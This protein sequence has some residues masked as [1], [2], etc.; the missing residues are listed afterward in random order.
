MAALVALA[1]YRPRRRGS[2]LARP[3]KRRSPP[4]H[5]TED[6]G[7]L[8]RIAARKC[9]QNVPRRAVAGGGGASRVL[10]APTMASTSASA[11]L[12]LRSL[13][14][15]VQTRIV[16]A[17]LDTLPVDR[18]VFASWWV[19]RLL[20][21]SP[22]SGLLCDSAY[23]PVCARAGLKT[24]V[25]GTWRATYHQLATEMRRLVGWNRKRRRAKYNVAALEQPRAFW[26]CWTSAMRNAASRNCTLF[27][28]IL[29]DRCKEGDARL[30]ATGDPDVDCQKYVYNDQ[31]ENDDE[32]DEDDESPPFKE[33]LAE[34]QSK[35]DNPLSDAIESCA[36]DAVRILLAAGANAAARHECGPS[37]VA[38]AAERGALKEMDLLLDAGAPLHDDE[39]PDHYIEDPLFAAATHGEEKTTRR[40]LERGADPLRLDRCGRTPLIRACEAVEHLPDPESDKLNV[41]RMLL[42]AGVDPE[43]RANNGRL[44]ID[45]AYASGFSSIVAALAFRGLDKSFVE[46]EALA[47]EL[48][49]A[50]V[51][52]M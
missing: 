38:F 36:T 4:L 16:A 26:G 52:G 32:N 23:E 49:A 25:C 14:L 48:S 6:V 10:G 7:A 20:V 17:V 5:F 15:D 34:L 19:V 1:P 33:R 50:A 18:A 9:M 46:E 41:V 3:S 43:V 12:C 42:E 28:R 35:F 2:S 47:D 11:A 40:L 13:P 45:V 22:V 29:L 37:L 21:E 27:L 24:A 39:D 30:R 44:A 8:I 31:D 51:E